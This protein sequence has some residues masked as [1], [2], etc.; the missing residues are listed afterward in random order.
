[1]PKNNI[2]IETNDWTLVTEYKRDDI[3]KVKQ[4][5]NN[6][7]IQ[8]FINL[9][10]QQAYQ[11]LEIKDN[12]T[13]VNN[14]R[15]KIEQLN[16]YK[17]SDFDWDKFYK[18]QILMKDN[19]NIINETRTIQEDY[20]KNFQEQETKKDINIKL[21]DKKDIYNNK[22]Q[23]INQYGDQEVS[24][25]K[26]CHNVTILVNGLPLV[27]IELK[28]RGIPLQKSFNE[29]KNYHNVRFWEDKDTLFRYIQIFVISN[30]EDTK[31]YSNTI[32]Y[33]KL[34]NE[35]NHGSK[36]SKYGSFQFTSYW[37]D[38]KNNKIADLIGF[39]RTFFAKHTILNILTK[40]CVF[41][42]ENDLLV[43][44][45]YQIAATEK[46]INKIKISQ[47][48][49]LE[50]SKS[51]G[52]VWHTTGSGKT[53]TSFKTAKL[54][55]KL[56]NI[57]RILFVV[58]RKDLDHQT[59]KEFNNFQKGSANATKSTNALKQ[60]LEIT[61]KDK[62]LT[63]TTIQKLSNF[64]EREYNHP[65][66]KENVVFIFD[67]CHRSQ[68]GKMHKNIVKHFKNYFM[69]GLT[70]TPILVENAKS[71]DEKT[72][73]KQT[74]EELFGEKLHTYTIVDAINDKN[75]LP[76]KVDYFSTMKAKD[77]IEDKEV[78]KIDHKV[79]LNPQRISNIVKYILDNFNVK[80]KRDQ[81][82]SSKTKTKGF[83]SIF[84]AESIEA[85]QKYYLEF[86]KQQEILPKN[87]R[88]KIGII[89][90]YN[91]GS[92]N[93]ENNEDAN[94][95]NDNDKEFLQSA[96]QDYNEMF[97]SSYDVSNNFYDYY[98]NI[99]KVT[100]DNKLDILIVVNMFLTGFDA[101][102]LNTLWL[103]KNLK[104][105]GLIQ[106]FSR[107]NR[108]YNSVKQF[109]HIVSFRDLSKE[110][111]EAVS[112]FSNKDAQG[113]ILLRPISDYWFGYNDENG[114]Y[115]IGFSEICAKLNKRYPLNDGILNIP[116]ELK[117]D[118]I[119]DYNI[120]LRLLNIV[121]T[122]EHYK[123]IVDP[124]SSEQQISN[125][126][127]ITLNPESQNNEI[128]Q[129]NN[130]NIEQDEESITTVDPNYIRFEPDKDRE[131][132]L[133]L[134][135]NDYK[136]KDQYLEYIEA[137][138]KQ[139]ND[140]ENINKIIEE[141]DDDIIFEMDLIRQQDVN[142]DYILSLLAQKTDQSNLTKEE[143]INIIDIV[144]G[145]ESLR[146][147]RELIYKF[148]ESINGTKDISTQW[149]QFSEVEK[150]EKLDLL[151]YEEKLD[152]DKVRIVIED[153]I[154]EGKLSMEGD[155]FDKMF[156]EKGS[157]F[158]SSSVKNLNERKY[159]VYEKIEK[160]MDDFYKW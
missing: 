137:R 112:L 19:I 23:I 128:S 130:L 38:L 123:I 108:I 47:L 136:Y 41:N 21:I 15:N 13:L 135:T 93:E 17:F 6:E 43:M 33:Q 144:K 75:V 18:Q 10:Q 94:N 106:A 96:I 125:S 116:N 155:N 143:V 138:Q 131:N 27:H 58:D 149:N 35:K 63:I 89:Y 22:L 151:V 37:S 134:H 86:K 16:N 83:N 50:S 66:F 118:F 90:S 88:I 26:Y 74:T 71:K 49:N 11:Y 110:V 65:V 2:V 54:A 14:L 64:I 160:Y 8:E 119:N 122:F 30:G 105:H 91:A 3:K 111:E 12:N 139:R 59:E 121:S 40:Y 109:G 68:F 146:S 53:L 104:M 24:K 145:S 32:R 39:A 115:N 148:L 36:G 154:R 76:F 81:K 69:F 102:T 67:E 150:K 70:G 82:S 124:T 44:R 140:N 142:I 103:D 29:I 28:K 157:L 97:G 107:T 158:I 141:I 78:D 4:L 85:A 9:L 25:D 156:K 147:K 159:R 77:F 72:S 60:N 80:T 31:Y 52:F 20:I 46:I 45:P 152:I 129:N 84:A 113:I 34:E 87:N 126:Y 48:N 100:K 42:V 114:N 61:D 132:I 51:G 55:T 127:K 120:Y 99:S 7:L 56:D 73:F 133:N 153:A 57:D 62:R 5:S 101:K 117:R 79:L 95:L 98:K 92:E 1:M